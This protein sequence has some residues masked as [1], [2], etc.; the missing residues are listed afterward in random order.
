MIDNIPTRRNLLKTVLLSVP[1]GGL[2]LEI[3][4]GQLEID[5][6]ITITSQIVAGL[7]GALPII[8]LFIPPPYNLLEPTLA[9]LINQLSTAAIAIA[10][11]TAPGATGLSVTQTVI[12]QFETIVF[13]PAVLA[14]L[15]STFTGPNGPVNVQALF[16]SIFT[17]V[18]AELAAAAHM[19]GA[20]VVA[21]ANNVINAVQ[22]AT[23]LATTNAQV[24]LA[25]KPLSMSGSQKKRIADMKTAAK[26]VMDVVSALPSADTIR[27]NQAIG[28]DDAAL[29]NC[30]PH[31]PCS[32]RG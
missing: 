8:Q 1:I 4:C 16:Q 14:Q 20:V 21:Q 24:L 22:S 27:K 13:S 5:Q 9:A 17:L 23:A 25:A 7:Q 28:R 6:F 31:E 3:G 19:Q 29:M 18:N 11:S 26:R 32:I 12:Q 15:P 30:N 2:T 10:N